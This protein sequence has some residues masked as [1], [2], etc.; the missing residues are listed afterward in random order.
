MD[1]RALTIWYST[2]SG[3][4]PYPL[5][6]TSEEAAADQIYKAGYERNAALERD[7]NLTLTYFPNASD[8]N[9][10]NV[11]DVTEL[12]SLGES[13]DIADFDIIMTGSK[14]CNAL[15]VEGFYTDLAKY[16][17]IKTDAPYYEQ[18][19]NKQVR[20][21]GHQFF[22]SGFYSV[23]STTALEV[24]HVNLDL[25]ETYSDI[26]VDELNKLALEHKWTMEKL[27]ELGKDYATPATNV[28]DYSLDQYAFI[29]SYNNAHSLYHSLGGNGIAYNDTTNRYSC[30]LNSPVEQNRFTYIQDTV[31]KQDGK[32][33]GIVKNDGQTTAF[34]NNA[35]PFLLN[36]ISSIPRIQEAGIKHTIMP[37]PCLNEGDEYQSYSVGWNMNFAGI[38]ALTMDPETSAYLYEVFMCYSYDY[39]YPA[40]YE[41]L[42]RTQYTPD[43]SS[44]QVFDLVAKSRFVSMIDIYSLNQSGIAI[45]D[46][47]RDPAQGVGEFAEKATRSIANQLSDR[48]TTFGKI[49]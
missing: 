31:A 40:G 20:F 18:L 9:T 16:D 5:S 24:T 30:T 37:P 32:L 34:V 27:L 46:V 15:A 43:N 35:A 42:F 10:G 44:V 23:G 36:P 13:M 33:V 41:K 38:P 22:A 21:L 3:W 11:R 7:F 1:G 6:V 12:R 14:A 19:V 48:I 47:C 45:K 17:V 26:T 28:G 4:S 29:C 49:S 8:P 25:L 39:I 2:L